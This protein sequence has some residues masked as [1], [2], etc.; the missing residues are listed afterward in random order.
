MNCFQ[1]SFITKKTVKII[2]KHCILDSYLIVIEKIFDFYELQWFV[3]K[4]EKDLKS[5]SRF[6]ILFG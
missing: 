4:F 3:N 1:K 2:I 5:K 6:P